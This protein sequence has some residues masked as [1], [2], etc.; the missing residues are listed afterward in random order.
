[1]AE[2]NEFFLHIMRYEPILTHSYSGQLTARPLKV[3]WNMWPVI[4]LINWWAQSPSFGSDKDRFW[5]KHICFFRIE[6]NMSFSNV[7]SVWEEMEWTVS[8]FLADERSAYKFPSRSFVFDFDILTQFLYCSSLE[9]RIYF[10]DY[11]S[12]VI[13]SWHFARIDLRIANTLSIYSSYS[14]NW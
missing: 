10:L 9:F 13:G 5:A 6:G 4:Y 2:K 12:S 1:M 14:V 11:V 8:Y 3:L 7:S